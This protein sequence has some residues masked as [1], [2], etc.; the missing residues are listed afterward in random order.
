MLYNCL[1]I[2]GRQCQWYQSGGGC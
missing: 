2:R 1:F